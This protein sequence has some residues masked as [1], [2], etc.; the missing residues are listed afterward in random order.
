MI[1][2]EIE[3]DKREQTAAPPD[4]LQRN[5]ALTS[6]TTPE[7]TIERLRALPQRAERLRELIDASTK[8]HSR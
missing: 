4:L 3:N 7:Q 8:A 2:H 1:K 5:R 6:E